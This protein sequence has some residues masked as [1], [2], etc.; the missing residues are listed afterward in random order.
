M[1]DLEANEAKSELSSAS[2]KIKSV[3]K[4]TGVTKHELEQIGVTR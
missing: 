2:G 1:I 4:I 3:T